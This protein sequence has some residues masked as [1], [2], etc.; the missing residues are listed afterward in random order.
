MIFAFVQL[1]S[2]AS[3]VFI[4]E[5]AKETD[6]EQARHTDRNIAIYA[7]LALGSGFLV[8]ARTMTISFLGFAAAK[9]LFENMLDSLL[10]APMWWHD[11]CAAATVVLVQFGALY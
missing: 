1:L 9:K 8:L 5:W 2:I 6:D 4:T 11:R 3:D 7:A 10:F